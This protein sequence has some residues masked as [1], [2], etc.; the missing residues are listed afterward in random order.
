MKGFRSA[1]SPVAA[2]MALLGL[3]LLIFAGH[4][5][6]ANSTSPLFAKAR[7]SSYSTFFEGSDADV[8]RRALS[9]S[10]PTTPVAPQSSGAPGSVADLVLTQ[11]AQSSAVLA[12]EKITYALTLTNR[13][14]DP[15]ESVVISDLLS[16]DLDFVSCSPTDGGICEGAGNDRRI[17]FNTLASGATVRV[18]LIASVKCE[19]SD[20]VVIGNTVSVNA[21][22]SDSNPNNNLATLSTTISNPPPDIICPLNI[23]AR[24]ANASDTSALVSYAAPFVTDNCTN[25][26]VECIP[27]TGSVFPLGASSVNCTARDAAG[28]SD[29]C[30]FTVTV[31]NTAAAADLAVTHTV[32]PEMVETNTNI[33]YAVRA[34]NNGPE[35][36]RDV[37]AMSTLP[38]GVRFVALDVTAGVIFTTE[39]VD[40]TLIV[41]FPTFASGETATI[42]VTGRV[43]C[44]TA[45]GEM[46]TGRSSVSSSLPDQNT[47]NNSATATATAI[48]PPPLIVCPPTVRVDITDG[49]LPDGKV[50]DYPQPIAFDNCVATV[51]TCNPPS[52]SVF[53]AGTTTVNCLAADTGGRIT[54]C[55]FTVSVQV[56]V[57]DPILIS[58]SRASVSGKKL[59]VFGN[60]F[61]DNSVVLLN[62]EPQ[63]TKNDSGSPNTML[64]AKKAGKKIKRGATVLI[65]VVAPDG[66]VSNL[67]SFTRPQ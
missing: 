8:M 47:A 42:R 26:I 38:A 15:A 51:V 46:L 61:P 3:G 49:M 65:Q 67:F 33:G 14:P 22:T 25:N 16:P 56:I 50:V 59:F 32:T 55:S 18:T 57:V 17:R 58:I 7:F 23:T 6:R 12:G 4:S 35:L 13:G 44:T 63:K 64:K 37:V 2:L 1:S 10:F 34:T 39:Q 36:A 20:G 11:T 5:T 52:G 28:T 43:I 45:E 19:V 29:S 30:G 62:N 60:N 53:S 21:A 24:T 31:T 66:R 48:N 41:R 9:T 54:N 27:P 40:N